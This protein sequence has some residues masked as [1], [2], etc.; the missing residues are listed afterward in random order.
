V[1]I[2]RERFGLFGA[3]AS[4]PI[5]FEG[6]FGHTGRIVGPP[7]M[8]EKTNQD[9][10]DQDKLVKQRVWYHDD[11]SLHSDERRFVG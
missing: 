11:T 2:L 6:S 9:E 4:G 8:K 3:F 10:S 7:D 5:G 1:D